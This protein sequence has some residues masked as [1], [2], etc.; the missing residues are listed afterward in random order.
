MVFVV[1]Q[2]LRK[3]LEKLI[4]ILLQNENPQTFAARPLN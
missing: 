4:F 1:A 2:R 3:G